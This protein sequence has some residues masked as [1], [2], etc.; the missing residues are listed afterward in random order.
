[1]GAGTQKIQPIWIDDLAAYFAA[2]VDK[3]EA[4]NRVFELGGPDQV[5]WNELWQR[6]KKALGVRRPSVD[7]RSS[8]T[9]FVRR[10]GGWENT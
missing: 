2:G 8:R 9:T 4:A 10:L 3:R 5:S 6:L 1:M 7:G